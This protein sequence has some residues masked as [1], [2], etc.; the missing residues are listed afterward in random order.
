MFVLIDN[1]L[2]YLL[3]QDDQFVT[4]R[5]AIQGQIVTRRV[6]KTHTSNID[7][8]LLLQ[9]I[10]HTQPH[11]E[12]ISPK[13]I[14]DSMRTAVRQLLDATAC[15]SRECLLI[16]RNIEIRRARK[17]LLSDW[18]RLGADTNH[19]SVLV[20]VNSAWRFLVVWRPFINSI[21]QATQEL[22]RKIAHYLLYGNVDIQR[23]AALIQIVMGQD[24]LLF[25]MDEVTQEIAKIQLYLDKMLPHDPH[26]W[27]KPL[28]FDSANLLLNFRDWTTDNALLEELQLC[29]STNIDKH[30]KLSV[31]RLIQLWLESYWQDSYHTLNCILHFWYDNLSTFTEYHVVFTDIVQLLTDEKRTKQL[32]VQYIGLTS[33]EPENNKKQQHTDYTTLFDDYKIDKTDANDELSH[34]NDLDDFLLQWKQGHEL[35][36]DAFA[37][38]VPAWSLAKTLTLLESALY[39][40]I[41]TIQ[42]TRHFKHKDTVIDSVFMFSNQ[43]SYYVLETTIQQT[44]TIS[45]WLRVAFGCLYLRNLN[46]LA[47]IIT[48]LQNH[49]V[50]RLSFPLSVKEGELFERLKVIVH[51]SNNYNVYRDIIQQIAHNELPCVPFTSLLIRDIT[52]IRD[53]N[54]TFAK[55]GT[56]VNMQKFHQITKIIAF[57]QYLQQKQYENLQCSD[58]T[59]RSLLGAMVEVHSLY[60]NNKDRAYQVSIAKIPRLT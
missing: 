46:S 40:N 28:P 42:F 52:F 3:E 53:G 6:N 14:L 27:K 30:E 26:Q 34:T 56:G 13:K 41:E 48:S 60:K 22:F 7:D 29:Y 32:K 12:N 18:Y 35:D 5:F 59:A 57:A 20:V 54:D 4:A 15:V 38:D 16:K 31:A 51:P 33:K 11:I 1:V 50:E 55:D 25:S 2:A 45:Y 8:V 23:I 36:V 10:S 58:N 19:D 39:L 21:Q 37:L 47:T 44:R 24:Y 17:R 9:F 43:L 49:S